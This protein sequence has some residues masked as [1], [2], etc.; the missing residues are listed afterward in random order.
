MLIG[1]RPAPQPKPKPTADLIHAPLKIA[2]RSFIACDVDHRIPRLTARQVTGDLDPSWGRMD[3]ASRA[4]VALGQRLGPWPAASGMI[5][6]SDQGCIETDLRFEL[7]R[8]A[9]KPD[10]QAFAYTL[11]SAPMGEASIRLKI[12]G[13][14]VTLLG[15]TDEQARASARR[16]LIDGAP[17]VL[18]ARIETTVNGHG[19]CAWAERLSLT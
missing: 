18:L 15:A 7:S 2:A 5:L 1:S 12:Q 11:A 19:E 13:P 14:G 16:L 10:W 17:V 9:D 3:R 8:L 6:V 4:L